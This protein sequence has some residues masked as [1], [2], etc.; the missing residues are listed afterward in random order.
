MNWDSNIDLSKRKFTSRLIVEQALKRGWKVQGF[1]SNPAIFLL[2]IPGRQDFIKIFS[3]SP[4]QMSYAAVKVAKDKHITNEILAEEGLPVPKE[5]LVNDANDSRLVKFL[6]ECREVVVKPLDSSH[7]KGITVGIKSL[8]RLKASIDKARTVT[9]KTTVL[10]Q[11][12]VAGEDIRILTINYE[13]VDAITRKPA[14]VVGDGENNIAQLIDITNQSP[15]RGEN[16]KT[17]LNIIPK[18]LALEFLGKDKILEIPEKGERVRV[19]GV[20]NVGMGGERVN[21][22]DS[23]PQ[24]LKDL[25]VKVAKS[26]ELPVCGVDFIVQKSPSRKDSIAQLNPSIIEVNEC[27]MLTMYEDLASPEQARVIDKYL[28]LVAEY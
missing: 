24:F 5:I 8:D 20:A 26:L 4:P 6:S 27:P 2:H 21:T 1:E 9:D 10:V 15:E 13:F 7:G 22:R 3:A 28:D 16:Y 18:V 12:Q 11:Q 17:K 25:A 23:I 14:S 19:I